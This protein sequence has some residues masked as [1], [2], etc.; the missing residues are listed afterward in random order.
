MALCLSHS[1]AR[2]VHGA[3]SLSLSFARS[4]QETLGAGSRRCGI[5]GR[6]LP[7]DEASCRAE[8]L[9]LRVGALQEPEM[10]VSYTHLT[11]PTIC[12]V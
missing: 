10:P 8:P 5:S 2:S 11:L 4:V 3:V 6:A 12:S 9:R 1:L 7:E